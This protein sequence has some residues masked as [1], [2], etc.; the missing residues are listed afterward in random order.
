MNDDVGCALDCESVV[1]EVNEISLSVER[2]L[3]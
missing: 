1:D 3:L 2:K